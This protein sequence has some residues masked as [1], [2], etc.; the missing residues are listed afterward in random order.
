MLARKI[1][2]A[3]PVKNVFKHL[4]I[5]PHGYIAVYKDYKIMCTDSVEA[6]GKTWRHA[7]I[8]RRDNKI[9]TFEDLKILKDFAIGDD[10]IAYQV[11][12]PKAEYFTIEK[13]QV[14]HLWAPLE[15]RVTPDF[16]H[17]GAI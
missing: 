1:P 10:L 7:S 13:N 15:G 6:D 3:R 17:Y 12:P 14:L 11:F 9:P 5:T 2:P 8:S 4:A 16:R